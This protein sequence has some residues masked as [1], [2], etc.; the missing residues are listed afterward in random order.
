L[1]TTPTARAAGRHSARRAGMRRRVCRP[2]ASPEAVRGATG[3][4]WGGLSWSEAVVRWYK[5]GESTNACRQALREMSLESNCHAWLWFVCGGR[6]D[7]SILRCLPP[8]PHAAVAVHGHTWLQTVTCCAVRRVAA[9][10]AR[11]HGVLRAAPWAAKRRRVRLP[12][13]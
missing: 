9:V 12:C 8:L 1:G 7:L 10:W 4:L 13:G 11:R 2:A 5:N 3:F 6:L